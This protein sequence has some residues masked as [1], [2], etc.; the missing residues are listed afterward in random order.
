MCLSHKCFINKLITLK[1]PFT[2]FSNFYLFRDNGKISVYEEHRK[3]AF[4]RA[5][6]SKALSVQSFFMMAQDI[7]WHINDCTL[8]YHA[9]T[10]S[11]TVWLPCHLLSTLALAGTGLLMLFKSVCFTDLLFSHLRISCKLSFLS[12]FGMFPISASLALLICRY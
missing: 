9:V 5:G 2:S 11:W 6:F 10:P 1:G 8:F 7:I 4:Q 3:G 12:A